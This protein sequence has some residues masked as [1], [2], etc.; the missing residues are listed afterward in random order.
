VRIL[1][2][3]L[4]WLG[5][6]VLA[7]PALHALRRAYP[8]AAL[9]VL[10]KRD[11]APLFDGFVSAD[12]TE[13]SFAVLPYALSSGWRGYTDRLAIVSEL[14]ARHFDLAVVLPKSFDAALW[15]ALAGI[16]RR[17]GWNTQG[18]GFLLTD[19]AAF[20][21]VAGG[22]QVHAY[23]QLLRDTL[24]IEG[25]PE[26]HAIPV[27]ARHLAAV[28]TW[29]ASRR[30]Q[31]EGPLVAL[32]VAAAYGPAK[33]WPAERFAALIDVLAERGSE[34]VLVGASSERARCEQ[35]AAASRNGALVAAGEMH[36]G[37]TVALLSICDAF[38]GNDSGAM[39]LAG[40]LGVPTVGLFGSTDPARTGPLGARTRTIYHRIE[41]SP[42]FARTCRYGH[43]DCLRRIEVDEVAEALTAT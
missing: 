37:E 16:P 23:L 3:E 39:H 33:E 24:G 43:Y 15:P 29:L 5:D 40:A 10:V 32:A 30:R 7:L 34:C 6:I 21:R 26:D 25:S 38:A 36:L 1:V 4:N 42:C 14:R 2:K 9:T 12:S 31:G 18:R 19:R 27:A 35:V 41:C 28:R 8:A 11:L 22:H 17:V 13:A 20:S